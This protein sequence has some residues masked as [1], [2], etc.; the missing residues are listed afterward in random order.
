M[1]AAALLV[2]GTTLITATQ[3]S[4]GD[5]DSSAEEFS[6]DCAPPRPGP[7]YSLGDTLCIGTSTSRRR[8]KTLTAIPSAGTAGGPTRWSPDGQRLL[9]R[10]ELSQGLDQRDDIGMIGAD[11]SSFVNLTNFPEHGNWGPEW[12]PD[13]TRLVF[14]SG[15]RLF[16]M[17][18]DGSGLHQITTIWGESPEWSPDGRLIAFMS[19]RCNCGSEFDIYTVRPDGS[20]LHRLTSNPGQESP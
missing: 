9:F 10:I 12:S 7:T 6:F 2:A 13:G 17:N 1:V 8:F 5:G 19:N 20:G 16:V 4:R 14:N 11:G 18:A 3:F 15:A